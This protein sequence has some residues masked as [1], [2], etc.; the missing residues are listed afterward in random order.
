MATFP[1][2]IVKPAAV[3]KRVLMVDDDRDMREVISIALE[4]SGFEVTQAHDVN[5]ALR[6]IGLQSFDV[7]VTDLH[8]PAAG[9]GLTVVSA[10]RHSNPHAITFIFSGHPAMDEASKAILDHTDEVLTKPMA[11]EQLVAAI[12]RRLKLGARPVQKKESIAEI[13]DRETQPTICEWLKCVKAEPEVIPVEMT[14]DERTAHLPALFHDLVE[15]LRR[16][17]PLGTRAL[18]SPAA[19]RHGQLR[20]EQGYTASMMVEES[21]MLQVSIFRTLQLNLHKV[22]FSVV[23]VNI[24]A[25]ADEVDSQ[26][27]QAMAH[28][29]AEA[30][31]DC[32]PL[33]A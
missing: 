14:D 8:M 24:M 30:K 19:A 5:S 7:L 26:L 33:E 12:H 1:E 11:P 25:I 31:I 3:A 20:R 18:V 27:A 16:P 2:T 15:R 17:L 23:L 9:D 6:L 29:I 32:N 13:L 4:F 22:N 28:Y 10:M 21:R